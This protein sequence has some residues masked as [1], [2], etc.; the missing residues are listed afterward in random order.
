MKKVLARIIAMMLIAMSIVSVCVSSF[1]ETGITGTAYVCKTKTAF[2]SSAKVIDSNIITRLD[3]GTKVTIVTTQKSANKFYKVKYSGKEG[4]IREDCLSSKNPSSSATYDYEKRYGAKTYKKKD[5]KIE[6]FKNV[7]RDLNMWASKK[8]DWTDSTGKV[9]TIEDEYNV[10][11][12][13]VDGVFGNSSYIAIITFQ[14]WNGLD[15]DGVA[16][17]KTLTKLYTFYLHPDQIN[18]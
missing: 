9:H 3:I 4:Y 8:I 13:K 5:K 16:G 10:F 15:N 17:P 6:A 1:A 7:Q 14:Q 18:K 2:R 12:L 11:P